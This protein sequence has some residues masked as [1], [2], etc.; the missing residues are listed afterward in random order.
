MLYDFEDCVQAVVCDSI[1]SRTCVVSSEMR[2]VGRQN[3]AGYDP[4][5]VRSSKL[6]CIVPTRT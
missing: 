1:A 5:G 6:I 3:E 2:M 4:A